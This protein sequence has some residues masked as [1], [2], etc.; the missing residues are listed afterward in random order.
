MRENIGLMKFRLRSLLTVAALLAGL[1]VVP[2]A[3]AVQG[4]QVAS[5]DGVVV[6]L[7]H[8]RNAT[9]AFCSGALLQPRLVVTA[10]HCVIQNGTT[11]SYPNGLFI[12]TPGADLNRDN[13]QTRARVTE[14]NWVRGY[15]NRTDTIEAN[16]FAVLALDKPLATPVL[17]RVAT[18]AEI[19]N[20]Q[21]TRGNV[22][23]LG[24]GK[25]ALDR[26]NDGIPRKIELRVRPSSLSFQFPAGSIIQTTGTS[27]E[28]ICPGDSGGPIVAQLGNELVLVGVNAG[29]DTSCIPSYRGTNVATGMVASYYQTIID[30][31]AQSVANSTPA[32]PQEV[33][34]QISGTD[35]TVTWKAP[36]VESAAVTGY[37]IDEVIETKRAYLGVYVADAETGG[38]SITSVI[39]DT[40]AAYA[41]LEAFDV[42]L[43]IDGVSVANTDAMLTEMRKKKQGDL[44]TFR[45]RKASGTTE[46]VEIRLSEIGDA[47]GF[48]KVCETTALQ[49]TCLFKTNVGKTKYRLYALSAKGDG[50][51][52]E[53]SVEIGP[54]GPPS[55]IQVAPG[56]K[57]IEVTWGDPLRVSSIP[58]NQIKVKVIDSETERVLCDVALTDYRCSFP[59]TAGSYQLAIF[60]DTQL[61]RSERIELAE[62]NVAASQPAKVTKAK[63]TKSKNKKNYL[64][65]WQAPAD[66]GGSQITGYRVS[67][68]SG[69]SLCRVTASAN[70]CAIKAT[71][72]KPGSRV[73]IFAV[74]EIGE[75]RPASVTVPR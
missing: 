49:L 75:G 38:V 74:N 15:Q 63:I 59:V 29:G 73:Q 6:A 57:S 35:L 9:R 13:I 16:D 66:N 64:V 3:A 4:G 23:H 46:N 40:P 17:S 2:P 19:R 65:S 18:T 67:T 71:A 32:E 50:T 69:T 24:Y 34:Y 56:N 44:V 47:T 31:G 27:S 43:A 51:A 72:V 14:V 54:G 7:V 68:A 11:I 8:G 36:S 5:P 21:S 61:G 48:N 55:N 37:R 41:K 25:L 60:A 53:F 28:S 62:V 12:A 10:A 20:L 70:K 30:Q 1:V 52:Y 22:T 42:V 58:K 26:D 39:P 33:T 45:I